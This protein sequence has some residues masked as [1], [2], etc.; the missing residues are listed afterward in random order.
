M[1]FFLCNLIKGIFIQIYKRLVTLF[2]TVHVISSRGK[3]SCTDHF[4]QLQFNVVRHNVSVSTRL[5]LSVRGTTEGHVCVIWLE[6][7]VTGWK[8]VRSQEASEGPLLLGSLALL[9]AE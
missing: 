4:I 6:Y 1:T 3:S 2:D 8:T 9:D 5:L 7:P